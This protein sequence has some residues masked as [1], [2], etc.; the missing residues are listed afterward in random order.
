MR[1]LPPSVI[2]PGHDPGAGLLHEW[3]QS[4]YGDWWALVEWTLDRGGYHGGIELL[5]SWFHED[6]VRPIP[7]EDTSQVPRTYAAPA[8]P[9]H[10]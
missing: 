2:L 4:P 1:D 7:D 6:D 10:P 5:K 8:S 3:R 9:K